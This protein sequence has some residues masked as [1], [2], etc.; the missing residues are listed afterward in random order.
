MSVASKPSYAAAAKSSATAQAAP[1]QSLAGLRPEQMAFL[2][3]YAGTAQD[4]PVFVQIVCW[5]TVPAAWGMLAQSYAGLRSQRGGMAALPSAKG[6][7]WIHQVAPQ[8]SHPLERDAAAA[9]STL[10]T[11]I[12]RLPVRFAAARVEVDLAH[13]GASEGLRCRDLFSQSLGAYSAHL[14]N[15]NQ[16]AC[17]VLIAAGQAPSAGDA[18]HQAYSEVL[19]HLDDAA[20]VEG[21]A[22]IR[23]PGN[24][25]PLPLEMAQLAASAMGR[26]LQDPTM[27]SPLYETVRGHLVPSSRFPS[28]GPAKRRR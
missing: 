4:K 2:G 9:E 15:A 3:E 26:H 12:R 11:L 18:K 8:L 16:A 24:D 5:P 14:R 25:V 7:S 21:M 23:W 10:A 28:N 27:A 1:G 22:L 6:T 19:P 17:R 13:A 20:R